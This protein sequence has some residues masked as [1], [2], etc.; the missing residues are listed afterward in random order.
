MFV[1]ANCVA[2]MNE[3]LKLYSTAVDDRNVLVR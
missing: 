1:V 2:V 3:L